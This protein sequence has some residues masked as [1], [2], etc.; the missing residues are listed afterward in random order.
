M[1]TDLT[2]IKVRDILATR[3]HDDRGR[4]PVSH[5]ILVV[6]KLTA[7]QVVCCEITAGRSEWRFNRGT[8]RKIGSSSSLDNAVIATPELLREHQQQREA[9]NRGMR[10][11]ADLI[12]LFGKQPHQLK[13][14]LEQTEALAKAWCSGALD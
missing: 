8:G 14:S 11:E 13:L 9:A 7:T 5:R 4:Y 10:A 12:D 1:A 2:H 3:R 6:E